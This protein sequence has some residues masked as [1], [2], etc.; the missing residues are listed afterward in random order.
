MDERENAARELLPY[1]LEYLQLKNDFFDDQTDICC[2]LIYNQEL[3]DLEALKEEQEL[4]E[5]FNERKIVKEKLISQLKAL[6]EQE[7]VTRNDSLN[8]EKVVKRDETVHININ[9]FFNCPECEL[10]TKYKSNL[11]SHI[12]VVHRKLKPFKCS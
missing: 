12:D 11:R 10:K 4:I 1:E 5:K 8:N 2:N 9:G 3:K 7:K 6:K